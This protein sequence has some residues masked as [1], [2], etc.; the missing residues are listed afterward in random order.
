MT[1]NRT[2][3]RLRVQEFAK[4]KGFTM[5]SLSRRADIGLSTVQ[6][7]WHNSSTGAVGGERLQSVDLWALEAIARVLEVQPGELLYL[8]TGDDNAISSAGI[9]SIG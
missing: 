6:R 4:A 8:E 7:Y 3:I 1:K 5:A 2:K 9:H